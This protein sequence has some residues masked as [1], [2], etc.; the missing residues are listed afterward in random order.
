MSDPDPPKPIPPAAPPMAAPGI[1]P[2][3]HLRHELR[4][5]LNQIIGYSEMLEEE[6]EESGQNAF[7]PDLQKIQRAARN[8]LA[9]INAHLATLRPTDVNAPVPAPVVRTKVLSSDL[10]PAPMNREHVESNAIKALPVPSAS[11]PR[12]VAGHLLVV[13]DNEMNRDMLSRRLEREGYTVSVAEN[14]RQALDLV[15]VQR[16]DLVLLDLMM[17]ELDGFAVLERMKADDHL[18]HIPVIMISALDE[19]GSVVRCIEI[20]AEDYLPK[21]FEPTLLRARIGACL[22][23]KQLRDQEQ[24]T[25]QALVKTQKNLAA[26]LAEAAEYVK[27]LFPA[28]LTGDVSADWRFIPST[29]LGGDAFGYHWLDADHFAMYLLDVCGH[30]VGAAASRHRGARLRVRRADGPPPRGGRRLGRRESDGAADAGAAE[31]AVAVRVLVEVLLVRV[32]R[33]VEGTG[34]RDL[35][36]DRVEVL[37]EQHLLVRVA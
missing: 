8:L 16:F 29:Q 4:T 28:P 23:K 17:P 5:P 34:R 35:G 33:V 2:M 21:P 15:R 27:S 14:G 3:S 7:V 20:G 11:G 32:L 26:E 9:V 31:A 18:R 1:D 36:G 19:L 30:G 12:V 10:A 24:R 6:A 13:D 25:Y 22:E 37:V